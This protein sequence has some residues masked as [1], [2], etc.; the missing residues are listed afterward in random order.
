VAERVPEKGALIIKSKD[1]VDVGN[2]KLTELARG[3]VSV[4]PEEL[5]T[6]IPPVPAEVNSAV[7]RIVAEK[8]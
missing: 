3:R 2:I 5:K 6:I 7:L 1:D 4:S 8:E